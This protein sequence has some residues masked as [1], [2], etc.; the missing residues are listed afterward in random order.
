MRTL[1]WVGAACSLVVLMSACARKGQDEQSKRDHA[2]LQGQWAIVSAE[3][4]GE[5]PPPGL[6]PS[7]A[8][9]GVLGILPGTIGTMQATEAI[10]LI[11]GIGEPMIGR[12]MLYDALEM[13][14]TTIRVRKDPNCPVC[15]V[16]HEQVQLIDY[17]QFCGVPAH[18]HV[19]AGANG[20]P[21]EPDEANKPIP[22]INA[23]P[24]LPPVLAHIQTRRHCGLSLFSRHSNETTRTIRK[25][26]ISSS[27]R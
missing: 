24:V 17:E 14:F 1:V 13:S 21:N 3:S 22:Q 15:G 12:M 25:K 2:A 27:A 8:E 26:R 16:P 5:P 7:C 18:D 20:N 4:N 6:V 23:M 11:T 10:K 19:L 9:A